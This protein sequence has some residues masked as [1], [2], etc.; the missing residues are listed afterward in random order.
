MI[1]LGPSAI[2]IISSYVGVLLVSTL[3]IVWVWVKSKKQQARLCDL[4]KRGI[5]RRSE[6]TDPNNMEQ[7]P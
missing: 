6:M 2:F 3:L 1:D 7:A 4:Q 5:V